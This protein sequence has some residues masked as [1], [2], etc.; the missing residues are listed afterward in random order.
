[1][2]KDIKNVLYMH[3]SKITSEQ[4]NKAIFNKEVIKY[5]ISIV[6]EIKTKS[7]LLNYKVE[8]VNIG[9]DIYDTILKSGL[10]T[11]KI[12]SF[13]TYKYIILG[14][15]YYFFAKRTII[16]ENIKF[17]LLSHD[18]Y[19][20]MGTIAKVA[21][22]MNIPVYFANPFEIRKI[23]HPFELY[24]RFT[25]Y[26]NFFKNLS[27]SDK[28]NG[29]EWST[30]ML[31]R[32]ISGEVGVMMNYQIKSA[33]GNQFIERQTKNTTNL[34]VVIATHCFFDSPNCLGWM[35]F[36]DFYEWISFLGELSNDLDFELYIKPHNDFLPGTLE[37]LEEL[38][39]NKQ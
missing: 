11:I 22:K 13:R 28:K 14:L 7:D 39:K 2:C 36:P 17:L 16:K 31:H 26:P 3:E 4:I 38:I 19:I 1:M 37:I 34:K 24:E 9:L 32:R 33:F 5:F 18:N 6:R 20:S 10:P 30:E 23:N 21:W 27:N 12:K 8:D 25:D 35:L 15:R 29:L